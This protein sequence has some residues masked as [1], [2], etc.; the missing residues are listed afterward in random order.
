M[1]RSILA[2]LALSVSLAACSSIHPTT[3]SPFQ[4][5]VSFGTVSSH[6]CEKAGHVAISLPIN[7]DITQPPASVYPQN[8][9][10][11][12]RCFPASEGLTLKQGAF[13]KLS[14]NLNGE[15]VVIAVY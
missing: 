5:K 3:P 7:Q 6:Y 12:G 2:P 13:V 8:A 4:V 14:K 15:V 1:T 10:H 11:I 9:T